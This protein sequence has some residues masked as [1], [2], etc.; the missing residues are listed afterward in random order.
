MS[1]PPPPRRTRPLSHGGGVEGGGPGV[2]TGWPPTH[3]VGGAVVSRAGLR[4][5]SRSLGGGRARSGPRTGW[6]SGLRPGGW[7]P[8]LTSLKGQAPPSRER[9]SGRQGKGQG[10]AR[11]TG[12]GHKVVWGFPREG[13][14]PATERRCPEQ[15][16]RDKAGWS[17]GAALPW[18]KAVTATVGTGVTRPLGRAEGAEGVAGRGGPAARPLQEPGAR[19][20]PCSQRTNA[21]EGQEAPC[22]R[23]A[24]GREPQP[25]AP[26]GF[27]GGRGAGGTCTRPEATGG[28]AQ[29]SGR[30]PPRG[31]GR[32]GGGLRS[33]KI[34][35]SQVSEAGANHGQ[36]V[37]ESVTVRE[38][39]SV[40]EMRLQTPPAGVAGGEQAFP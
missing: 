5:R 27:S 20:R 25:R 3:R 38:G 26:S 40:L 35:A 37:Q 12:V 22:A 34:W 29:S 9:Q 14:G 2:G 17:S 1:V 23:S 28:A 30:I 8:G 10:S 16:V 7:S 36:T 19:S 6:P 32:E 13:D 39:G 24:P 11:P 4:A 31:L 33:W 18:S 15:G 21:R